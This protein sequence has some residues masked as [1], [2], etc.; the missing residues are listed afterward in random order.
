[1]LILLIN[2]KIEK[3]GIYQYGKNISKIL[4]NSPNNTYQYCEVGSYA[5]YKG[6][7][8]TYNY[9]AVIYNYMGSTL[10][11]LNSNTIQKKKP[12]FAIH[13]EGPLPAIFDH[14][15]STDPNEDN[16]IIRPLFTFDFSGESGKGNGGSG[17]ELQFI[18]YRN[19]VTDKTVTEDIPII[20]SFG[21]GF[22]RKGFEKIIESV[23]KEYTRA[24][25]KLVVPE[26]HFNGGTYYHE[27]IAAKCRNLLKPG[28]EL[29]ITD[30]F[31]DTEQ[32]LRFLNSNA[33]NLFLYE[34]Q[35]TIGISSA[36]DYA[37]S[38][39]TPLGITNVPMFRH[40]YRPEISI[41]YGIKNIIR[42]Y[43]NEYKTK[44]T[45]EKLVEKMDSL[46]SKHLQH[47]VK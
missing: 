27:S 45:N 30:Q 5:E 24:I 44:W 9:D 46:L 23:N 41:D 6:F 1:M 26:A 29:M 43:K 17:E 18:E 20:G 8:E 11:W 31:F 35:T 34:H 28:I 37:L 2:H 47:L 7:C 25:I 22:Y 14:I 15:L 19:T 4:Q 12:N 3:C 42:D 21:F 38:V 10:P 39:D 16:G 32:L 33:I 40:I 36:I 13:H